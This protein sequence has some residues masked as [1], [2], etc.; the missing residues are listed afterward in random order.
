MFAFLEQPKKYADRFA[1]FLENPQRQDSRRAIQ[2]DRIVPD[3]AQVP[4]F[5]SYH[6]MFPIFLP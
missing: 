4:L 3:D 1:D 2:I 6:M 5:S